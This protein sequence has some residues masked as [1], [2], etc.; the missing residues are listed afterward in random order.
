MEFGCSKF[1]L[2][3]CSYNSENKESEA[4][5]PSRLTARELIQSRCYKYK[6][7]ILTEML[8]KHKVA[9]K[10]VSRLMTEQHKAKSSGRLSATP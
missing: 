9:A 7:D 6:H 3:T 5:K 10:F 2:K 8:N 1:F 4:C